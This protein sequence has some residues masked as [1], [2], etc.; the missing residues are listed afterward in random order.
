MTAARTW[1]IALAVALGGLAAGCKKKDKPPR[2]DVVDV[3]DGDQAMEHAIADAVA[4]LGVFEAELAKAEP[5]KRYAIK[6]GFPRP[7]GGNEHMWVGDVKAVDG[8]FAGVLGNE[9]RDVTDVKLGD[10]VVVKRGEVSDW[11]ITDDQGRMWGGY[12]VR[13]LMHEVDPAQ[14]ATVE[15]MLQPLPE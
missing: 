2:P 4:H 6:K 15:A 11:M 14:R 12:T 1:A 10:P 8:G 7:G 13:A 3:R 9:P 5:G